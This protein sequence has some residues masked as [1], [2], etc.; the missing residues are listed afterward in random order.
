MKIFLQNFWSWKVF[1]L[2]LV[3][4]IPTALCLHYE[5]FYDMEVL[6]SVFF[7][8]IF[9]CFSITM[10]TADDRRFKAFD[11]IANIKSNILSVWRIVKS[12]DFP[13]ESRAK[14]LE[15]LSAIFP[16]IIEFLKHYNDKNLGLELI[17]NVDREVGEIEKELVK[18]KSS[19]LSA[20]EVSRLYHFLFQINFSFEKLLT[21]KEHR[22]PSVLRNF[23]QF[24]LYLSVFVLAPEFAQLGILGVASSILV[25][26][27]LAALIQIQNLIENPFESH[28]DDINFEF[29]ERFHARLS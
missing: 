24:S 7:V 26:F 4:G 18:F 13:E 21:I 20:P 12:N 16:N 11:E 23:L 10:N 29:L 9:F 1:L 22:T 28:I 2:C 25:S 15:N 17:Q 14:I 5:F 19:D 27:I 3:S 6:A 8:G